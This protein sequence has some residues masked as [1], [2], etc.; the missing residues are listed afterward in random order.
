MNPFLLYCN[1]LPLIVHFIIR[2]C[3][4]VRL[5]TQVVDN[6]I[7]HF[8]TYSRVHNIIHIINDNWEVK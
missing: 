5:L 3:H 4:Y 7:L 6:H 2:L 1:K 8:L